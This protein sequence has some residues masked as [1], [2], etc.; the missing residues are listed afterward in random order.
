MSTPSLIQTKDLRIDCFALL[1]MRSCLRL[2]PWSRGVDWWVEDVERSSMGPFPD[3]GVR[4][5]D[6]KVL[7]QASDWLA[8]IPAPVMT[9][10]ETNA[11]LFSGLEFASLWLLSRSPDAQKLAGQSP[12]IFLL[13]L[14]AGSAGSIS[15]D[16]IFALCQE[17]QEQ[18][19][20]ILSELG[21]PEERPFFNM[22]TRINL[23]TATRHDVPLVYSVAHC[24]G[25]KLLAEIDGLDFRLL[26]QVA[27]CPSLLNSVLLQ[28]YGD[29]CPVESFVYITRY[30]LR[31]TQNDQLQTLHTQLQCCLSLKELNAVFSRLYSQQRDERIRLSGSKA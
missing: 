17:P 16:K 8:E 1:N 5:S 23:R 3:I 7:P 19:E 10:L 26:R 14:E 13:L 9:M 15:T 28:N 2:A 4:L 18:E 11:R 6:L 20:T 22:L 24:G 21:L 25:V 27:K 12:L 30:L 29:S 31:T